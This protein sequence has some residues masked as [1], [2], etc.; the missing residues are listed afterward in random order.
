M[1]ILHEMQLTI[2]IIITYTYSFCYC[3]VMYLHASQANYFATLYMH[4]AG[5][6]LLYIAIYLKM[7]FF[8]TGSGTHT[9]SSAQ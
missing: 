6:W 1:I 2:Y 4:T 7:H 8:G 9:G 3:A 5:T